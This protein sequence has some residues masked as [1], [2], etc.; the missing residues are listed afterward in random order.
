MVYFNYNWSISSVLVHF[1]YNRSISSVLVHFDYNRSI[2]SVLVHFDYNRSISSFL[3]HFYY[4][5]SISS[6]L[7]HFDPLWSIII[8]GSII[9]NWSI[10]K[11]QFIICYLIKAILALMSHLVALKRADY[12]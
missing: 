12:C 3:V 1:D 4:N 9:I 7:D 5:R 6:F 11:N 2:S 10:N 8:I